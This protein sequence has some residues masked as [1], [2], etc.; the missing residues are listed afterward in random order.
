[1]MNGG[2][3]EAEDRRRSNAA[4]LTPGKCR[5][6]T[7]PGFDFMNGARAVL[8]RKTWILVPLQSGTMSFSGYE[9]AGGGPA[10]LAG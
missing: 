6:C 9:Q 10:I 7:L 5:A 3:A 4:R 2:P 8:L 1:V